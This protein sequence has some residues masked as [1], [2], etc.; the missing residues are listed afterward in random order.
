MKILYITHESQLNGASKSLLELIKILEDNND[1]YVLTAFNKGAFFEELQKRNVKIF[2]QPYYRWCVK[3]ENNL[4]WLIEKLKWNFKR[5]QI[6]SITTRKLVRIVKEEHIDIIHTNTSVINIGAKIKSSCNVKHVWH[7][8]EFADLDF[9]MYP[10]INKKKY[11]NTMNKM[12]DKFICNSQAVCNHYRALDKDKKIVIYNGI[13]NNSEINTELKSEFIHNLKSDNINILIAG[14]F[15]AAKGQNIAI[16]AC[17]E[18]VRQGINNF[19]LFLAGS[20]TTKYK[21]DPQL[22][23][24]IIPLGNLKDLAVYRKKIDIEL[25]CS[26]AEAFGRVTIEAMMSGIPVIGSCS[27]GTPELIKNGINGL[28]FEPGDSGD[29]AKK[30]RILIEDSSY[31][32]KLGLEAHKFATQF[33]SNR[34]AE[35]IL[36]L[37][38]C[39]LKEKKEIK[40]I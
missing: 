26:R 32:E 12:C 24:N 31:R 18:L 34:C 19:K 13:E 15:S 9:Q 29:L 14:R 16:D 40:I 21:P 6:N 8:R 25:V 23:N 17:R 2:I 5:K 22:E 33:T 7:I 36:N 10:L 1:I 11:Y 35:N 30:I 20:E 4:Q 38:S 37:Y 28:L 39:I 3:K 27:G